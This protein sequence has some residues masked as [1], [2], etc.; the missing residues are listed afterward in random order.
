MVYVLVL[1]WLLSLI[2]LFLGLINP[3]WIGFLRIPPNRG[4]VLLFVG[5]PCIILMFCIG[6]SAPA[7]NHLQ[8][9]EVKED[10][11]PKSTETKDTQT[12]ESNQSQ[13]SDSSANSKEIVD[14]KPKKISG[15]LPEDV[16]LNFEKRGFTTEKDIDKEIPDFDTKF[17]QY[18]STLTEN[19]I[20]YNVTTYCEYGGVTDVTAVDLD[21]SRVEPQYNSEKDMKA[22]FE[23][24]CSIPYKG[25]DI[26][27]AKAFI[28]KNFYKT[29]SVIVIGGV[30]FT[31]I[32]KTK[33]ARLLTIEKDIP[34]NN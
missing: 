23:Y 13:I 30:R 28:D 1:L 25:A 4:K 18:I 32:G 15:I 14:S 9:N 21:A 6:L 34:E 2:F 12:K 20:K 16:Y 5:L 17:T 19:G 26:E 10:V 8:R 24:G 29:K 27:K 11:Q 7:D 31:L 33:F 22:F 3:K